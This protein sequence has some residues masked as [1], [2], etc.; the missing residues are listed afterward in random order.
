MWLSAILM[1]Q[2]LTIALAL[3]ESLAPVWGSVSENGL[4]AVAAQLTGENLRFAAM[5][6]VG[7]L[8]GLVLAALLGQRRARQPAPVI[9]DVVVTALPQRKPPPTAQQRPPLPDVPASLP[10]PPPPPPSTPRHSSP[11]EADIIMTLDE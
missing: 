3:A 7:L 2:S 10:P 1:L 6:C 5:Y 4:G 9:S 11:S 8:N